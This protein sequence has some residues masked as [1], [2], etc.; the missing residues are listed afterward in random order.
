MLARS[1]AMKQYNELIAGNDP[2][3]AD[4]KRMISDV[5]VSNALLEQEAG[6]ARRSASR[7]KKKAKTLAT[8]LVSKRI[9]L[10]AYH[11]RDGDDLSLI[12]I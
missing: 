11:R 4:L 6:S 5:L 8:A 12:H 2:T 1:K 10:A 7:A 9:N 3:A